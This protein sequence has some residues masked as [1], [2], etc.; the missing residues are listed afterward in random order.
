MCNNSLK[1]KESQK[2]QAL[3]VVLL[4]MSVVL[5]VVLGSASRSVTEVAT[6]G[7]EEDALRA[8]SAAEAGIEEKLLYPVVGES[9]P[10]KVDPS[11]P[12]SP[13]YDVDV[14]EKKLTD[15]PAG[16][17]IY[18]PKNLSSGEAA[19]FYL[20]SKNQDGEFVCNAS[21]TCWWGQHV[22]VC[23]GNSS[24]SQ[25]PAL[26]VSVYFDDTKKSLAPTN[27]YADVEVYRK[28]F[29]TDSRIDGADSSNPGGCDF[30][31]DGSDDFPYQARIIMG[32]IQTDSGNPCS[33]PGPNRIE[34]CALFIK[35][36]ML[37]ADDQPIGF[38]AA[39]GPGSD[40]PAQGVSISS[41]GVAG[42][43]ARRVEVYSG[44]P[45][46]HD[47]FNVA[48]YSADDLTK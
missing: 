44:F 41:E 36:R 35:A 43:S 34:G 20:T 13:T 10:V 39:P 40:I 30:D 23:Y 14:V 29:D 28:V 33:A 48:V 11:D 46:V 3:I 12:T 17:R 22:N 47:L 31:G 9:G 38:W 8:F 37:Y 21:N 19:T 1:R 15:D 32:D 27:N 7:Y 4:V 25:T 24:A 26:E 2:G 16:K 42:S 6:T 18:Y 5:T 45:E